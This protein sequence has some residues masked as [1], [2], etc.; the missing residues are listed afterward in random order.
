MR[1]KTEIRLWFLYFKNAINLLDYRAKYYSLKKFEDS[2]N[3][4]A[5]NIEY[6]TYMKNNLI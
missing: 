4:Y 3:T 1:D 2:F 5:T 6:F